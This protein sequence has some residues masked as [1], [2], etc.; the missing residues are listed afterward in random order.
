[1]DFCII[2]S[3][4]ESK[5][6]LK[7]IPVAARDDL[8]PPIFFRPYLS[9]TQ[10]GF[11]IEHSKLHAFVKTNSTSSIAGFRARMRVSMCDAEISAVNQFPNAV[12][13]KTAPKSRANFGSMRAGQDR[14]RIVTATTFCRNV[15]Q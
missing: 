9:L 6:R 14:Y 11:L 4:A 12:R 15:A 10:I 3:Q 13:V 8:L 5:I 2:G 7:S 1:M